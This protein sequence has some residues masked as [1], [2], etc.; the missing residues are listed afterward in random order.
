MKKLIAAAFAAL[1]V[2]TWGSFVDNVSSGPVKPNVWNSDFRAG[3]AYADEHGLPLILIYASEGCSYCGT[4][5]DAVD[6]SVVQDWIKSHQVILVFKEGNSAALKAARSKNGA[7]SA[8][9]DFY[10]ARQW[11]KE[12]NAS[13]TGYPFVGLYR[14]TSKPRAVAFTGRSSTIPNYAGSDSG[15]AERFAAV[16]EKVFGDDNG[17]PVDP[18]DEDD[19]EPEE[20]EEEDLPAS[21]FGQI[22]KTQYAG[23]Y[24]Q[25]GMEAALTVTTGIASGSGRVK[26]SGTVVTLAGARRNFTAY[27]NVANATISVKVLGLGQLN[28]KFGEDGMSGSLD[29]LTVALCDSVGGNL[30][31]NPSEFQLA[32][33]F[34]ET[35]N[36]LPILTEFLPT[37]APVTTAGT[38][39]TTEKATGSVKWDK[40][41]GEIVA[42][43]TNPSKLKLTYTPKTGIFKGSFYVYT[44]VYKYA[45]G[46]CSDCGEGG[47]TPIGA[48]IRKTTANVTGFVLNGT[49]VGMVKL[50]KFGIFAIKI[51]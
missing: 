3:K 17:T 42:T 36:D 7:S 50:G 18:E 5:E 4:F 22:A 19:P 33:D 43:G 15:L 16:L 30:T 31:A 35:I 14:N 45:K 20:D 6:E 44:P 41:A 38:K 34:P 28:L 49:G 8:Y 51:R 48:T 27:A 2:T 13:L 25:G 11:L 37:N 46:D 26:V 39:W 24:G 21:D 23:L 40:T 47:G 9:P 32:E 29:E 1:T 10:A 12:A